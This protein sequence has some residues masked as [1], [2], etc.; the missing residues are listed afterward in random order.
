MLQIKLQLK[1]I[2]NIILDNKVYPN[3]KIWQLS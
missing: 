2:K 3:I 1:A